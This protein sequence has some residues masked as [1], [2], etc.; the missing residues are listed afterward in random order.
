[1]FNSLGEAWGPKQW[2]AVDNLSIDKPWR[3]ANVTIYT[4]WKSTI[5]EMARF[6]SA[7]QPASQ[8]STEVRLQQTSKNNKTIKRNETKKKSAENFYPFQIG[9]IWDDFQRMCG[10]FALCDGQHV[11]IRFILASWIG[12]TMLLFSLFI[13]IWSGLLLGCALCD[14]RRSTFKLFALFIVMKSMIM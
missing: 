13:I 10:L 6:E 8:H 11:T 12:I 7:N 5:Y 4:R 1:M 2:F 14:V 3:M 9:I